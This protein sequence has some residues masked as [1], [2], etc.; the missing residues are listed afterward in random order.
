MNANAKPNEVGSPRWSFLSLFGAKSKA[1]ATN[2]PADLP[3]PEPELPPTARRILV[4]DDDEV[5]RKSTA[6]KLKSRGYAVS[7]A[8]DGP[9][10]IHAARSEK[11]DLIL[12]DLN[13][14]PDVSLTWDGFGI[15]SWLRR[16]DVTKNIPVIIV[17]GNHEKNLGQRAQAAGA[18]GLFNKPL[19]FEPLISLIEL[20]LKPIAGASV[21]PAKG[22]AKD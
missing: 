5:V 6:L 2:A 16:L 17:T 19:N 13:F 12:L 9:S 8:A 10:A 4:V 7:T 15:L 11:P 18:A 1:Q 20:R 22:A 3:A 21:S 14:P